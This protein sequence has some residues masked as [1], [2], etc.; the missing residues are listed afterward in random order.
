MKKSDYALEQIR[1]KFLITEYLDEKGIQ[2]EVIRADGVRKYL[3][4]LH[5]EN[6]ASF[7]LYAPFTGKYAL[8]YESYKC[9][10]CKHTHD[11]VSL[12]AAMD[13]NGNY[14]EA[15][16]FFGGKID[17]SLDGEVDYLIQK[18]KKEMSG[19]IVSNNISDLEI[20]YIKINR[21]IHSHLENTEYDKI[22]V[23]FCEDVMRMVDKDLWG[24]NE[25]GLEAKYDFI[26]SS[27]GLKGRLRKWSIKKKIERKQ[28]IQE[29][30]C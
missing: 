26:T 11:I 16:K 7:T 28:R 23:S 17:M 18:I 21:Y 29:R 10:G 30:S 3:C 14:S 4:P 1:S 13:F 25:E 24:F 27:D 2:P 19:E 9:F 15:L 22:E 12:C 20:L 5:N 6:T 8:P